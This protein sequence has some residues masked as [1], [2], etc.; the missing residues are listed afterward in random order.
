MEEETRIQH[1]AKLAKEVMAT[2]MRYGVPREQA[3]VKGYETGLRLMEE[4]H[5]EKNH[6]HVVKL[7]LESFEIA[8]RLLY[9]E[10]QRKGDSE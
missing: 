6:G 8:A 5:G 4:W 3:L 1:H 9:S 10:L 2:L 7:T